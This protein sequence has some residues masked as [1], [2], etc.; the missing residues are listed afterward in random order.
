MN[1]DACGVCPQL[2][3]NFEE[4]LQL[5]QRDGAV[6]VSGIG[7]GPED[8]RD[9]A[10]ALFGDAIRAIPPAAKVL[11]GGEKD[12]RLTGVDHQ[13]RLAAH[14]DGYAYGDRY[15]D[16]FLLTCVR[17]SADGGDSF[18]VDGYALLQALRADPHLDWVPEA[19]KNIAI[20]QTE[21]GMQRAIGPIVQHTCEGR[22]LVRKTHEQKPAASS[23]DPARDQVMIDTWH[24]QAEAV[25]VLAP[26]FKLAPGQ[27]VIVDNYRMLH[28]RDAY[29][30]LDRLLWR[31][32]IWTDRSLG[33]P[34]QPLHSDTRYAAVAS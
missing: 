30:D 24:R 33:I 29:T 9:L 21:S 17:A 20:D 34:E 26:R 5:L 13:I 7:A 12:R 23:A 8:A 16:Y 25:A 4:A 10:A 11:E 28:G 2:A 32:W 18:L 19:L 31:V 1:L 27:A 22:R 3:R 14:T 6:I 15:P